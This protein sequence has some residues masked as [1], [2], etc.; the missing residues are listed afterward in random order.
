MPQNLKDLALRLQGIID[1]AIDGIITIDH[2]GHIESINTAGAK[3]FG[4]SPAEVRG[5]NVSMLMPQPYRDQHDGYIRRYQKTREKR[6]IGIGREVEGQRK[7]GS[8]FPF[9]LAVGEVVLN[10]R[11]IYTGIIHDLSDVHLAREQM[12]TLNN[13]LEQRVIDRTEELTKALSQEKEFSE[14][15]SRF[16]TMASHEFRTPLST[17]LSSAALIGKYS[18]ED[19]QDKRDKH[20]KKIKSSV[21]HLTGILNDFLSLSKLEENKVNAKR[22]Y[23]DIN[24]LCLEVIEEVSALIKGQKIEHTI[25]GDLFNVSTDPRIM[26][27]ILFN[28]VSNALK[29]S[30]PEGV[31]KCTVTRTGDKMNLVVSDNGI[32]IPEDEQKHLF[33]RF[34]RASNVENIQ[35]TGLGL[36]IVKQYVNLLDGEITFKSKEGEGTTFSI[37]LPIYE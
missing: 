18:K 36:N 10:D 29:Y 12:I 3:L 33:E 27:N 37:S 8:T 11:V 1:T 20:I 4:Y 5:N 19:Q 34:F 23:V 2:R 31:I 30:P 15:K 32:G 16:V 14:L 21:A 9:R 22:V 35:G 28:L 26:K 13:E 25:D 17:I 6:I 7:N 24:A